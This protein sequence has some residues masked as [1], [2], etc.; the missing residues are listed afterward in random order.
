MKTSTNLIGNRRTQRAAHLS[1]YPCRFR[2]MRRDTSVVHVLKTSAEATSRL[3]WHRLV[4]AVELPL[5]QGLFMLARC[6]AEPGLGVGTSR[7]DARRRRY[8]CVRPGAAG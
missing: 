5:P 8:S 3:D 4:R 6:R 2:W 7:G 1:N